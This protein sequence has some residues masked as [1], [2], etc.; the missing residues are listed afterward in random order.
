MSEVTGEEPVMWGA[1]HRRLWQLPLPLRQRP[2]GRRPRAGFSP[3]R[4]AI[5]VYCVPGFDDQAELLDRLSRVGTEG[6]VSL[7]ERASIQLSDDSL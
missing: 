4:A 3:R 7:S 5:T 1:E 2:R 6:F